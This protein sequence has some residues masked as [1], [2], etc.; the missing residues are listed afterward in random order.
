MPR[1]VSNVNRSFS[2]ERSDEEN[3]LGMFHYLL[4][5][6]GDQRTIGRGCCKVHEKGIRPVQCKCLSRIAAVIRQDVIVDNGGVDFPAKLAK[7]TQWKA[8]FIFFARLMRVV[9]AEPEMTST[10]VQ[11]LHEMNHAIHRNLSIN[12]IK[13]YVV[14]TPAGPLMMDLNGIFELGGHNHKKKYSMFSRTFLTTA[15][16]GLRPPMKAYILEVVFPRQ[17]NLNVFLDCV[18]FAVARNV[19]TDNLRS[20]LIVEHQKAGAYY[21]TNPA[22]YDYYGGNKVPQDQNS[23]IP[24]CINFLKQ[25]G[26]FLVIAHPAFGDAAATVLFPTHGRPSP[27]GENPALISGNVGVIPVVVSDWTSLLVSLQAKVQWDGSLHNGRICPVNLED[28]GLQVLLQELGATADPD[29]LVRL[30]DTVLRG[31]LSL[32]PRNPQPGNDVLKL[33]AEGIVLP[34]P[35]LPF[36]FRNHNPHRSHDYLLGQ[37]EAH[38]VVS[39]FGVM[40]LQREGKFVMIYPNLGTDVDNLGKLVFVPLGSI[41]LIPMQLYWGDK[42]RTSLAGNPSIL[43]RI[44]ILPEGFNATIVYPLIAHFL[45]LQVLV[46]PIVSNKLQTFS[47]FIGF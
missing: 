22:N 32:L 23:T 5:A 2:L 14:P 7:W 18:D 42:I 15:S 33:V 45:A 10:L 30:N 29:S 40:P 4:N 28:D 36:E 8:T 25:M 35:N 11:F 6:D 38:G 27:I 41:L 12:Q 17:T 20:Q 1:L 24:T 37:L 9:A 16:P 44:F 21:L 19:A 3:A 26:N 46:L 13:A 39:F 43:L 34:F 31:C 47:G